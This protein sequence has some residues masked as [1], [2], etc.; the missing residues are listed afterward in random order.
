MLSLTKSKKGI[1]IARIKGGTNDGE[2][3]YLDNELIDNSN[4]TI[5]DKLSILD[6]DIFKKYKLDKKE[7]KYIKES[8]EENRKPEDERL[9]NI[10]YKILEEI[11]RTLNNEIKIKDGKLIPLP[12][13]DIVEKLYIS[14]PSGAGKSTFCGNWIKEYLDMFKDGEL[15]VFSSIGYDDVIDKYDPIRIPLNYE[16]LENPI[17]P[18]ELYNSICVFDDIDTIQDLNIRKY[19]IGLRDWLLEQGRHL[20][21]RLLIT[22]HLMMDYKKTRIVLNEATTTCFFPKCGGKRQAKIY[23][24]EYAGL[25]KDEIKKIMRLPSRWICF[26]RTYPQYII[27]EKGVYLLDETD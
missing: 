9:S 21:I 27:Y 26:Y 7:T 2:F 1:K 8:I 11:N 12:K 22:S 18:V 17:N 4:F 25:E 19:L 23:L 3:I 6:N 10:Y 20:K 15:F 5:Q 16:L 14:A 13:K 24:T